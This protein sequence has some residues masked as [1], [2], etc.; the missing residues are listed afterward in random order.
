MKIFL[1][2]ILL[3]PS[4]CVFLTCPI[5]QAHQVR[6]YIHI[7]VS[8]LGVLSRVPF[9]IVVGPLLVPKSSGNNGVHRSTSGASGVKRVLVYYI[10]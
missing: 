4:V 7:K 1:G 5:Y 3:L 2:L 10:C 6:N 9:E 8:K